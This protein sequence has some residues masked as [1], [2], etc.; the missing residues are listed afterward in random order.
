MA[1]ADGVKIRLTFDRALIGGVLDAAAHFKVQI[2]RPR[3]SPGGTLSA[4][5]LDVIGVEQEDETTLAL[6]L[7]SGNLSSLQTAVGSAAVI[8]DGAGPLEG[9][10][11]PVEPF[12]ASFTPED[13]TFKPDVDDPEH[14]ELAVAAA[15]TLTRIYYTH[16]QENE[17]VSLAVTAAGV[18]THVGDL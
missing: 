10:G 8:Y 6:T 7:A 12:T 9:E 11:G 5:L 13:V 18:L 4:V 2:S 16:T 3:Y 15:G 17:H 14:I 1:K